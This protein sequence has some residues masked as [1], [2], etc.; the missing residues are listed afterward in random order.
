M[1]LK[2][3][4]ASAEKVVLGL[5]GGQKTA[6]EVT[7]HCRCDCMDPGVDVRNFVDICPPL[8]STIFYRARLDGCEDVF[9]TCSPISGAITIG[10]S[11]VNSRDF[12]GWWRIRTKGIMHFGEN[13]SF[14]GAQVNDSACCDQYL[15]VLVSTDGL[16]AEIKTTFGTLRYPR[17]PMTGTDIAFVDNYYYFPL[18]DCMVSVYDREGPVPEPPYTFWSFRMTST[19]KRSMTACPDSRSYYQGLP[20]FVHIYD[21]MDAPPT[22]GLY[23]VNDPL[24]LV[25][26][27]R[28]TWQSSCNDDLN[29]HYH[30]EDNR[31]PEA[32]DAV[33]SQFLSP[34]G[35]SRTTRIRKIRISGISNL[36]FSGKWTDFYTGCP[37]DGR[38]EWSLCTAGSTITIAGFS[39]DFCFLN[40]TRVNG[41]AG[42]ECGA[43]P[44]ALH[45]SFVDGGAKGSF[46]DLY[47]HLLVNID[48]SALASS[49]LFDPFTRTILIPDEMEATISVTHRFSS[50][51]EYP[52]FCAALAALFYCTYVVSTHNF[53]CYFLQPGTVALVP[54]WAELAAMIAL[55][56]AN[57]TALASIVDKGRF[58]QAKPNTL[59]AGLLAQG[60]INNIPMFNDPYLQDP[61]LNALA[62]YNVVLGNY[63]VN[64]KNLYCAVSGTLQPDQ[65]DPVTLGLGAL[66]PAPGRARF[67]GALGDVSVDA[68]GQ[69][70]ASGA[71]PG[72]TILGSYSPALNAN[73]YFF[74]QINPAFVGGK[75]YGYIYLIDCD[76]FD[77]DGYS[78]TGVYSPDN[79]AHPT[80][81][82]GRAALASIYSAMMS[83]LCTGLGCSRIYI[84]I[85]TNRG[86]FSVVPVTIA[87]FMGTDRSLYNLYASDNRSN[88]TQPIDIVSLST[89]GDIA[90]KNLAEYQLYPSLNRAQYP[91]SMF[92]GDRIVI[93]GDSFTGSAGE[94]FPYCFLGENLDGNQG[95]V[96]T[97][98]I[99]SSWFEC[100]GADPGLQSLPCTKY[101][102]SNGLPFSPLYFVAGICD[103]T[104]RWGDTSLFQ[105]LK[106]RSTLPIKAPT[107]S[108][109]SGSNALPISF[110]KT[111]WLDFGYIV[112]HPDP[113]LP[114]WPYPGGQVD[115]LDRDS[116][117]DRTLEQ[118]IRIK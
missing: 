83:Y 112:P 42:L 89:F 33:Y 91:R 38:G 23:D 73:N 92:L 110:E 29:V 117:R 59:Y 45:P 37:C 85:R 20:T 34:C 81:R 6:C 49:K 56:P 78:L 94:L 5:I 18:P 12:A 43:M 116:Y 19:D 105:D 95:G 14:S 100:K 51:M 77:I 68:S 2:I 96:K 76:F 25:D 40:G 44:D 106:A 104:I 63:I 74:G 98:V 86:G 75:T 99:G 113:A 88:L 90:K 72:Y 64:A 55:Y 62:G 48:S 118:A 24:F 21:R 67:V 26:Y 7:R 52:A 58:F 65:P 66:I 70:V 35:V 109:S 46:N 79:P 103:N 36:Y 102:D 47:F 11:P 111:V 9:A 32:A 97:Q 60:D 84:D 17:L 30:D 41:V 82:A 53:F 114:G 15:L 31:G 54:T 1:K 93:V 16:Y 107:L 28:S 87:E 13:I 57:P 80:Q 50:D 115:K 27:V 101:L 108:G 10:T 8:G 22:F 3:F 4:A 39:G 61:T 71:P 69:G